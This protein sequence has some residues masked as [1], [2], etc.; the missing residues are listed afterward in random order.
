MGYLN[1]E[2]APP[3]GPSILRD[4]DKALGPY[5]RSRCV[6]ARLS[7]NRKSNEAIDVNSADPVQVPAP[8]D[9]DRKRVSLGKVVDGRTAPEA[10]FLQ[11]AQR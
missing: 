8:N 4:A 1:A 10:N 3:Y 9:L 5:R 6:I 2:E 11:N 7:G